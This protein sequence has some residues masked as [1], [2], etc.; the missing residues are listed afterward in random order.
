MASTAN[1]AAAA[2]K[3]FSQYSAYGAVAGLN[4]ITTLARFGTI[5]FR[6]SNHFPVSVGSASAPRR[7]QPLRGNRRGKHQATCGRVEHAAHTVGRVCLNSHT[8]VRLTNTPTQL[9]P[10]LEFA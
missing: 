9:V 8:R 2:L 7:G 6:S 1:E 10:V 4:T 5:S 3:E